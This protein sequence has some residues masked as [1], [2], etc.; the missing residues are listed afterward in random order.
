MKRSGF[1][2]K[3]YKPMKRTRLRVKG[4]NSTALIKED[5]QALVRL[6]VTYRDGGCILR[7]KRNCSHEAK[8]ENKKVV[9]DTVIQADHLITRANG[10]TFADTR[11]IVCICRGCHMWKKYHEKE[12]NDLVRTV[13]PKEVVKLWDRA[14]LDHRA[15][16]T[17]KMDWV[18]EKVVLEKELAMHESN[19]TKTINQ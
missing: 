14:D 15:H 4:D 1:K 19:G 9:S 5:I 2:Q 10:A 3:L 16:K 11:L 18:L 8:V 12:Y 17:H 13:L 6:I 7:K